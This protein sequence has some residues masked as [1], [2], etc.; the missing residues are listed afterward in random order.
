MFPVKI[1]HGIHKYLAAIICS[2]CTSTRLTAR[3]SDKRRRGL[4][5][6]GWFYSRWHALSRTASAS[7][8]SSS[9]RHLRM[10]VCKWLGRSKK[11][12]KKALFASRLSADER[13]I[14]RNVRVGFQT[15]TPSQILYF[16][17]RILYYR[18]T[19]YAFKIRE[20]Y[21]SFYYVLNILNKF[22]EH[23]S[24]S[25][26]R[27]IDR[28]FYLARGTRS[29]RA[30]DIVEGSSE[31]KANWNP[32]I[33]SNHLDYSPIRLSF[34]WRLYPYD[35]PSCKNRRRVIK[36]SNRQITE[37]DERRKKEGY[38][39]RGPKIGLDVSYVPFPS[40]SISPSLSNISASRDR[41][42]R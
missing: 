42:T 27:S 23:L 32:S 24:L 1:E 26:M 34:K 6:L 11:K 7:S 30:W 10:R 33:R 29:F 3:L 35:E 28:A 18:S 12:R 21:G 13:A 17:Y 8:S 41:S 15:S 19:Y 31:F 37:T 22:P 4:L 9:S 40:R 36:E 14:W 38:R 5:T 16:N 25:L 39:S 20:E 2:C